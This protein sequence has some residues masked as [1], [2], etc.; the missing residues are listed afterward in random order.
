MHMVSWLAVADTAALS[1]LPGVL[2]RRS[3]E[4][5]IRKHLID[6]TRRI[7]A[8]LTPVISASSAILSRPTAWASAAA[9]SRRGRSL[10]SRLQRRPPFANP[11]GHPCSHYLSHLAHYAEAVPKEICRKY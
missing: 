9:A 2:S 6:N 3:A 4:Q 7:A 1:E 10:R 11:G 8:G 5:N